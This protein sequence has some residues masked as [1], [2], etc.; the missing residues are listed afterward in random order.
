MT[1]SL[2]ELALN[3]D[4]QEKARQEINDV[5]AKHEGKLTYEA[6]LEMTY[7]DQI[8]NDTFKAL[9]KYPPAVFLIRKT[10]QDYQVPTTKV[11]IQK[12]QEIMIPVYCIH[13]DPEIYMNPEPFDPARFSP[14]QIRNRHPMTFLGFGDGPRN[15]IG[16][17]FARM[18]T[19]IG[20][21]TMLRN[22]RFKPSSKTVIP[23]IFDSDMTILTSKGGMHLGVE[24]NWKLL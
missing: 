20:L 3:P 2:Y 13:H 18:Q 6:V 21:I 9:R 8:L 22:Y 19:R 12:G 4:I 11:I 14:K 23:F 16:M 10:A 17:R 15:C 7:I 1:Y 5:L 24:K